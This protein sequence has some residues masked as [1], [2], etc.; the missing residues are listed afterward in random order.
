M[1]EI[2]KQV[3]ITHHAQSQGGKYVAQVEGEKASAHLKWEPRKGLPEVNVA[4]D[5]RIAAYTI[6]P[7]EIGGR[8]I[9]GL[10]VKRMICDAREQGFK[11]V[12]QCSY[13]AKKF[14]QNPDW[15]DLRA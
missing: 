9:A 10:L 8:G 15:S 3:S 1:S 2:A 13:V 5:V 14:A 7:Q 12:P 11:I 4:E 6:V